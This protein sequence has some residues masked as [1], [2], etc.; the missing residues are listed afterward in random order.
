MLCSFDLTLLGLAGPQG[1]T[2]DGDRPRVMLGRCQAKSHSWAGG[3]VCM[4]AAVTWQVLSASQAP[5]SGCPMPHFLRAPQPGY[6]T[7][8][9][10]ATSVSDLQ[11]PR[12]ERG[13]LKTTRILGC[14]RKPELQSSAPHS[15]QVLPLSTLNP[16]S[17]SSSSAEPTPA[18]PQK[19]Q[20]TH[21]S[22]SLSVQFFFFFCLFV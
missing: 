13:G 19:A 22:L 2:P 4:P 11:S 1:A 8:R 17:S 10:T 21:S 16:T 5:A 7:Q 9:R 6:R 20:S 14:P 18:S 15:L 12:W 3:C